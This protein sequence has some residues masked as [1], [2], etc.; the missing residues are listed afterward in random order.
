M[1]T[2]PRPALRRAVDADVHPALLLRAE[3]PEVG[4]DKAEA[5]QEGTPAD[6]SSV[7]GGKSAK[8]KSGGPTAKKTG[9]SAGSG[10]LAAGK[11]TSDSLR[12]GKPRGK[13]VYLKVKV[14]KSLRK[15]LR[16][17]AAQSDE[18]VDAFVTEVLVA[19]LGDGRWW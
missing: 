5:V 6:G 18:T 13:T 4:V 9:K 14:P 15:Q 19:G 16:K 2:R 10:L 1:T 17:R 7:P 3:E 12:V 11:T 8:R